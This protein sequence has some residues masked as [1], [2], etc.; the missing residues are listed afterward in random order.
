MQEIW[1]Q[2]VIYCIHSVSLKVAY[3]E[4]IVPNVDIGKSFRY[5]GRFF[6][7]PMDNSDHISELLQ[8]VTEVIRKHYEIPCHSKDN[9]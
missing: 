1:N 7:S 8:L 5:L 3:Y 6:N 4:L 2:K 9:L